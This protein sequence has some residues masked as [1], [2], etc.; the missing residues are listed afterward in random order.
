[1]CSR[2]CCRIFRTALFFCYGQLRCVFSGL[3]P[4]LNADHHVR[5]VSSTYIAVFAEDD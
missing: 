5:L 1:M 4:P 3:Q 2:N